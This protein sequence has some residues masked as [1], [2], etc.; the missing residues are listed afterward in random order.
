ASCAG[1]SA[2]S[3]QRATPAWITRSDQRRE[4]PRR[5]MSSMART[6]GRTRAS[7]G[8]EGEFGQRFAEDL[9]HGI[10]FR[11][12]EMRGGIA[13]GEGCRQFAVPVA[14]LQCAIHKTALMFVE[15]LSEQIACGQQVAR[16][17]AA[18][19]GRIGHFVGLAVF[20]KEQLIAP[21]VRHGLA[22]AGEMPAAKT[23]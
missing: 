23:V 2:T 7:G 13:A 20:A 15:Q 6:S 19:A 18:F 1:S 5:M 8:G 16:Q 4:V 22:E 11:R 17:I 3:T 10:A 14:G 9:P 21:V 12:G